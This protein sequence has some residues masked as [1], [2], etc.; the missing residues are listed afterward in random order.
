MTRP[1]P[2]LLAILD[3]LGKGH[4]DEFD[5]V[6]L[7]NT[8]CL[9]HLYANYPYSWINASE[10]FVGLPEGQMG[11]SEV[12]HMN[13]GAG[14]V[15]M[16]DLPRI[17]HAISSGEL[18]KN[19]QLQTF[20]DALKN[21]GGAAHLMGLVSPGGVHAHQKHIAALANIIAEQGIQVYIHAFLDGRDT[22]PKSAIVYLENLQADVKHPN[23]LLASLSGRYFA[24]DRDKRWD[25]V[26]KAFNAITHAK[27]EEYDVAVQYIEACY[28]AEKFDEFIPPAIQKNYPGMKD[29]DGLLMA[30]F[31]AD[32]ARQILTAFL[33]PEFYGFNRSKKID[34]ASV[35]GMVEYSSEIAQWMPA[36]FPPEQLTG[37]LGEVVAEAG[38][39]QLRIAETEKYAHVTFFFNGGKEEVFNGEERILI[40]SPKVATYDLQPEMSAVEVTDALVDAIEKD[41]F[42]FIVV[43]YANTDMVG[44]TG[45]IPA[46]IKAV[47]TVDNC[48][49]RV[50][51]AVLA[52]GGAMMVTADHGNCEQMHD[53]KTEQAHT[54]HTLNLVPAILVSNEIIGK[55]QTA[56]TEGKLADIAPTMLDFLGLKQPAEMTGSSL[57][58]TV[59]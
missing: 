42:D 6:H 55:K 41:K 16:Q 17:D 15:V 57:L 52:K 54:A 39:T 33:A 45:D 23:I 59:K 8:P 58:K 38:L 11:N 9:D 14:R 37:I 46:A 35:L 29:G 31:R 24:M 32:R 53:P 19:P 27:A 21:S 20:I 12:G 3:G 56:S 10:S 36:L 30:N 34:F 18:A 5:A 47:E 1:K 28:K 40:P 13:I 25:R 51:D 26:E 7:A 4:E 48:L 22:P 50:T 44:H 2:V 49:R 43:N